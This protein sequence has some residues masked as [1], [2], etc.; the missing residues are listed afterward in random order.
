MQA[1]ERPAES[2]EPAR[3]QTYGRKVQA[4]DKTFV[5]GSGVY[6]D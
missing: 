1:E 6:L 4:E 3:K 2:N 5:V